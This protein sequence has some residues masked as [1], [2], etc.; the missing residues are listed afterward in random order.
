[1][2]AGSAVTVSDPAILAAA[3]CRPNSYAPQLL[4]ERG[5]LTAAKLIGEI[6][7]ADRFA[8]DA[9]LAR[10]GGAAPIPGRRGGP[11]RGTRAR[12]GG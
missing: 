4:A 7:G 2:G 8:T 9:K 6:A 1:V 11:G 10:T 12:P 3:A 5:P